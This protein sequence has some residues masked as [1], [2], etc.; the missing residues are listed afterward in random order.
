MKEVNISPEMLPEVLTRLYEGLEDA[1]SAIPLYEGMQDVLQTLSQTH[2]LG[3]VSTNRL[4]N[5]ERYLTAHDISVFDFIAVEQSVFE[6]ENVLDRVCAERG[7][8]KDQVYYVGG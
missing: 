2:T 5:I 3:I 4:N 8:H 1:L 6:K 7:F